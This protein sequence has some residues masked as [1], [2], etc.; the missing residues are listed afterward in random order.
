MKRFVNAQLILPDT[1]CENGFLIEDQGKIRGLGPMNK[2][3]QGGVWETIAC[4]GL[5][6]APGFIDIHC[7]GGG[8]YDFTDGTSEAIVKA[9][10]FHLR[11]GTTTILP[12][13]CAGSDANLFRA[14]ENFLA[15][16]KT[17]NNTPCLPGLHL[18]GPYFS[19]E[20]A[21]AQN[22]AHIRNPAP[23]HYNRIMEAAEG[24]ILRWSAAPEL[25]GALE[26]ARS[27]APRRLVFSIAHSNAVYDEVAAAVDAGFT[28]V[29]HLYSGMSAITRR[30]GYRFLGVTESAYLLDS[31]SVEIIADG[32]HLP[33]ELLKL[34]VKCKD[35][36][37][38]CL[39]SDSMRGAGMD[40]GPS[41]LGGL[42]EG[43]PVVIENGIAKLPDRSAF[44]GSVATSDRLV[45]VMVQ[46]AGLSIR[47]AVN[48]ISRNPARVMGF[49]DKG[50]LESGKDA[51]LVLFD[52][53][54]NVRRVFVNGVEAVIQG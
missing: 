41:V 35:N 11:H 9:A 8:G 13:T 45:R 4:D 14:I 47:D 28:H 23:E 26:M 10:Q 5:Y 44:A 6:L 15:A 24:S 50:A 37:K 27:L 25:E 1:I 36:N 40:D 49:A 2:I 7:H 43:Q 46:K 30:R 38:I 31:L 22:P 52:E 29:T 54:I 20:Q 16:R 51:D 3:P 19:K 33:P 42:D 34:I 18:E 48:M 53:G 17:R 32:L 12:T 39:V 21:G